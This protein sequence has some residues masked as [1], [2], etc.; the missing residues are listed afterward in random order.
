[1]TANEVA[2]VSLESTMGTLEMFLADFTDAEL[3]VRPVP[4]ANH[5]AWQLG[6]IILGEP[7]LI[8]AELPN[9]VYPQL[10]V[11]FAELHGSKGAGIDASEGFLTKDAYLKLLK[12]YRAVTVDAVRKLSDV[13]LGRP[14]CEKMK[15][16]GPTLAHVILFDANH[17]LMHAGQL[18]VIRRKLGK[19][20]LM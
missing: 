2:I 13:E 20:I 19:P 5:A 3:L 16:A 17:T 6:N 11:G 7:F 14:S 8:C 9:V 15:W 4:G 18:S 1:M 12:E 10:P